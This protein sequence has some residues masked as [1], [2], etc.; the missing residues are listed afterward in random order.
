MSRLGRIVALAGKNGS[1]KSR[2]LNALEDCAKDHFNTR[3]ERENLQYNIGIWQKEIENRPDSPSRIMYEHGVKVAR[4]NRERL[5]GGLEV[6]GAGSAIKTLR[7]V[8]KGLDLEDPRGLTKSILELRF[9]EAKNAPVENYQ[10]H[11]LHYIQKVQDKR[12]A[13]THQEYAGTDTDRASAIASYESLNALISTFL[14]VPLGR[15]TEDEAT[16]FNEPLAEAGLSEGQ[17][18]ILQL[19]VALHAQSQELA[20][21]V[22]ILDELEN[23]LHPSAV[24]EFLERL[25]LAAPS[26][27][28]WIATHSV[29]LLAHIAHIEPMAI[30]CMDAGQATHAGRKP[31]KILQ[32]L[33]GGDDRVGQLHAF[34]G[35]PSVL[36][37]TTYAIESLLPPKVVSA[38]EHDP[39]VSQISQ[40]LSRH[41]PSG[42]L[43]ILDFGAGKGRLLEGIAEEL[44]GDEVARRI[45]Y[46]AH[47]AY[48]SDREICCAVIRELYGNAEGR[49]FGSEEEF[50]E[51]SDDESIDVIVMC[52]VLHEIPPNQWLPMFAS[53]SMI[54]RGLRPD[55]FLLLVEDQRIPVG[56][57][58][59]EYGFLVLDTAQ[60]KTLFRIR[61]TDI[62]QGYF[63][64]DD[65]R[66]DGR[67][68]AHLI[69]KKL[70]C[71]MDKD[72]RAEAIGQLL[73]TA[74]AKVKDLRGSAA[75]YA[76]G[77]MHGFWTQQLANAY[78]YCQENR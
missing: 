67:L 26:S 60:L 58:A 1:G 76:N 56:E 29:P 55:G 6:E 50:F 10:H 3:K 51:S 25:Q 77:Q 75:S 7:F 15:S 12:W 42:A 16:L 27:Q 72:S 65:C 73:N 28:I 43:K 48:P 53:G 32:A 20:D 38:G 33:L 68:K 30:W 45:Q 57:K 49:Y 37:A 11:C 66:N 39:Q 59:H 62:D 13:A 52:N 14:G 61:Q 70:L 40:M 34:S 23:H 2:L 18:I 64:F 63:L 36:A 41:F 21:T 19:A 47:D 71:R 22:F 5:N 35:M 54:M 9:S 74:M 78:M 17:K 24:I 69:S 8:P 4:E 44:G 31:E 46:F